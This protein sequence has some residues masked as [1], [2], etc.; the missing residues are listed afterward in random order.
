MISRYFTWIFLFVL[1]DASLLLIG[2]EYSIDPDE[3]MNVLSPAQLAQRKAMMDEAFQK[4]LVK[5]GDPGYVYD[6]VVTFSESAKDSNEWDDEEEDNKEKA[7]EGT[8]GAQDHPVSVSKI[9]IN[10]CSNLDDNNHLEIDDRKDVDEES[11]DVHTNSRAGAISESS[12]KVTTQVNI[13]QP[14]VPLIA[15]SIPTE[16]KNPEEQVKQFSFPLQENNINELRTDE[17]SDKVDSEESSNDIEN[18]LA[19]METGDVYEEDEDF[20]Q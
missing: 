6:K 11:L 4:N 1:L 3:D 18:A 16:M 15:S 13:Q 12:I 17:K 7:A 10:S 5:P 9:T 19:N 2:K 20:W 8:T 14:L